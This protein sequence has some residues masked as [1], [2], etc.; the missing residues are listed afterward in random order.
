V[1]GFEVYE[2]SCANCLFSPERIVSPK[3][4]TDVLKDCLARDTFFVCHKS[5][6]SDG[7]RQV[8]CKRFYEA[9]GDMVQ[10]IQIAQRLDAVEFVPLPDDK[11]LPAWREGERRR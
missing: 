5:S 10:I 6:L 4:A 8:C 9:F 7:D 2:K 3:R 11:P 1:T